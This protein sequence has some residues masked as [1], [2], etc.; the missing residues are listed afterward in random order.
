MTAMT[1]PAQAHRPGGRRPRRRP[2]AHT[3]T[4]LGVAA[5]ACA[6]ALTQPAASLAGTSPAARDAVRAGASVRAVAAY[7]E[8]SVGSP[9]QVAWVR[10]AAARFLAAELR[11]DGAGACAIL[12]ARL[13]AT[14]HGHTC[15]QRWHAKLSRLLS[16]HGGRAKL[17]HESRA[18]PSARV[19]VHG[20]DASIELPLPLD[21]GPNRFRWTENCWMLET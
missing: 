8:G 15:A 7:S 21:A 18:V 13:R 10:S 20:S 17:Q 14:S 3:I 2:R 1:S 19:V 12:D 9:Q 4:I 5:L 6:G 11:A 16:E